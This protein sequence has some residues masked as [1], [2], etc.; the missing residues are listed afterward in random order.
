MIDSSAEAL[1]LGATLYMP[2]TNPSLA[3]VGNLLKYPQLR[4]VVFCTED[5]VSESDL[6]AA[7]DNL[8]QVLIQLEPAPLKRFIRP[9]NPGLLSHLLGLEG[10]DRIDGFVLPKADLRS[11]PAFFKI[12]AGHD[13]FQVL[14]IIE[15]EAAFDLRQLYRL[16]DFLVESPFRSRITSLRI[17]ALDLLSVLRLRREP[18][19][20]IYDT[21]IG[22]IIDQLI[23]IFVPAGLA[24]TAPGCECFNDLPLLIREIKADL[25]RGLFGKTVLHPEQVA[26]VHEAY[27]VAP[28]DLAAAEAVNDPARPAVFRLGDRMWEKAVHANWATLTEYRA[29][30]FG[31]VGN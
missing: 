1:K 2:A 28:D 8:A 20:T 17:G 19:Q 15:T 9:R 11:L 23:S 27:R 25:V 26:V 3:E 6:P 21:P 30:L 29:A 22:Y 24:L 18:G 4:S 7:L 16:R 13:N 12:L 31:L 10:I 5:S 14:P